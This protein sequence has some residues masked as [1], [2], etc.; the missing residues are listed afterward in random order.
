M[1]GLACEEGVGCVRCRFLGGV[2]VAGFCEEGTG[3]VWIR[4]GI[5]GGSH[6][7]GVKEGSWGGN[8]VQVGEYDPRGWLR[9]DEVKVE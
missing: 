2:V 7:W 1:Q 8:F 9:D 6:Y 5:I 4:V 3:E